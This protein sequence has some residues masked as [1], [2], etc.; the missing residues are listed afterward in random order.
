[1]LRHIKTNNLDDFFKRLGDRA[2]KGVYFYRINGYNEKIDA[3]IH[4]YY[5]DARKSGV[6]IEGRIPNPDENNLSY[7][8]EIMGMDFQLS[9]G[10]ISDRIK[11]WLPR[12]NDYQREAVST[13]IY[14]CLDKLHKAGKNENMLKNAYIKFMCWLY[15]KFER[16][17][18]KLGNDDVPKILYEADIS[19]YE[20]MLISI[21]SNAGCDVILLQYKGD[22]EYLK[23]DPQSQTSDAL[24]FVEGMGAFPD[25]YSLKKIREDIQNAANNARLYGTL[26]SIANC[27]N[28]WMEEGKILDNVRTPV[29]L[30]GSDNRFF[31]N[32]FCRINGVE[33]KLTYVNELY[34]LG[35]EI[36]NSKRNLMVV[37]GEIPV[38]T[39]EEISQVR[40]KNAYQ[41]QDQVI[42]DL[43]TN[44]IFASSA[45]IQRLINKAFIDVMLEESKINGMNLNK[46]INKGVYLI[47]WIKRYAFKILVNWKPPEVGCFIHFGGCRNEN[48]NLFMKLMA[49]LPIDVL[50]F[51]PNLNENCTLS[52]PLLYEQHFTDSLNVQKFPSE[53]TDLHVGTSAYHAERELDELMYRDSGIYRN[54][55]YTR[56]NA[57]TLNTMYEEIPIL[58]KEEAKYR[59]NFATTESVVSIPVIFSKVSG[60]KNGDINGYWNSVKELL[61]EETYLITEAPHIEQN[62][63]NPMKVFATEFFKNGK[64]QRS[65]IKNHK[66]YPYAFL[67]EE[68][69]D[70]MLDKLQ[71]LIDQ[72]VIKGTFENGTE[73]TIIGTVLNLSKDLIRMIQ[74]FDFT[75]KNP[76]L[77]YVNAGE[78]MLSLEDSILVA[79]LNLVGFDILFFVPTGYQNVERYFNTRPFE[80]HQIGEYVYDLQIPNLRLSPSKL[81]STLRDKIFKR[82]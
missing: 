46:L 22:A 4:R 6:V 32:C 21:L 73:Y 52:D 49:R 64:L 17:L 63:P 1:M 10:F 16:V 7:F 54:Q 78:K 81:S 13:A 48:E 47:C 27:T 2:E 82:G 42:A 43:S 74:K 56:A 65:K 12:M 15:Y 68:V 26:P 40:R 45:E 30:R 11:K 8:N 62:A 38:P 28:A 44:I 76:K 60:V 5:E 25:G 36:K 29:A 59:P 50:I 57:I 41:S 61:K 80:E 58:W 75:K 33:D 3:F 37:N 24:T 55:Q 20:L 19:N 14:D 77:I 35:L 39:M 67:R 69:Q 71:L 18:S 31:Y 9:L 53:T 66:D 23:S 51:V 34:Q 72:K 70:H 79:F